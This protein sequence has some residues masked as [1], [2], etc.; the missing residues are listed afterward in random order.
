MAWR[1]AE[2]LKPLI[3]A[4]G[5]AWGAPVSLAP[6]QSRAAPPPRARPVVYSDSGRI[7]I[8]HVTVIDVAK[9]RRLP[10]RTVIVVGNHITRIG[11][12]TS[13]PAPSGAQVVDGRGAFLIPGLWDMHVHATDRARWDYPLF[14]A[15]GVTGVRD[16]G[17]N[18]DTVMDRVHRVRTGALLG[19]RLFVAGTIIDGLPPI[20]DEV[21]VARTPA[22]GRHWVDS[23]AARGVDF[24]KAYEMLR[25]EVVKAIVDEA[26]RRG[27]SVVGHAPLSMDVGAV[28]DL[29]YHSLEHLR[30]VDVACSAVADSVRSADAA[31][32]TAAAHDT[33][34]GG[35]VRLAIWDA[36]RARVLD[37]FDASRCDAL[38][39]RF[40]RN[41]TWQ[42]PTF[43][44]TLVRYRRADTTARLRALARYV[45]PRDSTEWLETSRRYWDSRSPARTGEL[46][47]Q[48]SLEHALFRRMIARR[49]PI[50]A[51]TDVF[52]PWVVPG[53]ALHDELATFVDDGMSPL[54][55]LRSATLSPAR[56]LHATDSLG[57]IA[58][59]KVADLV[60]LEADPLVDI[61]NT[62]RIRSVV[63]NGRYFDRAALDGLLAD[64]ARADQDRPSKTR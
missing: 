19:P 55:A 44:V 46:L 25:P 38:L 6:A 34:P 24:I 9:G 16:M 8:A 57:T 51:G 61:H 2:Q 27:L 10:D 20:P 17:G 63:A 58:K 40:R 54:D 29:G 50:L 52:N 14:L 22:E 36:R 3:I 33:V 12:S 23:L 4:V 11:P 28:S 47:R 60:L 13:T 39:A 42:V 5:A 18:L 59:G 62:T 1:I 64:A 35:A 31:R 43:A 7:A 49:V 21:F 45:G 41:G 15:N 48:D 30:N 32:V 53:F 56:F 26:R 37:S